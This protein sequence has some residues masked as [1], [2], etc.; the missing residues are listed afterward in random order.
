MIVE[1]DQERVESDSAAA[2]EVVS[3][4]LWKEAGTAIQWLKL[5]SS[6]LYRGRGVPRGNGAP[7]VLIP[8]LLCPDLPL[9]E[10]KRW[11]ARIGYEPHGSGIRINAGCLDRVSRTLLA[12]VERVHERTGKPVHLV[13]HS[14]G[15]LL[16]RG[17]ATMRPELIA[18]VATLGSPLQRL[19]VH[20]VIAGATQLMSAMERRRSC[21]HA[22][23]LTPE[24]ACPIVRSYR[25]RVRSV[26]LTSIY[27]RGDGIVDWESCRAGD[28]G[29]DVEVGGTHLGLIYNR[30]AYRAVAEHLA[31][32]ARGRRAA[33]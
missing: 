28:E 23:C 27:T 14:L 5:R 22:A 18:S 6:S 9:I 29:R 11:L 7:V 20:S 26:P 19:R 33:A 25:R 31:R 32:A 3:L 21:E 24:C 12:R 13:G 10:M 30:D 4:P 2:L 16:A 1:H 8:G 15:G 17:L